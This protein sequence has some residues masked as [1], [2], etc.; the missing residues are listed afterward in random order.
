M[1]VMKKCNNEKGD[2][3]GDFL[4]HFNNVDKV[5]TLVQ[6][7]DSIS[8]ILEVNFRDLF[9]GLIHALPLPIIVKQ[10]HFTRQVE[11][12]MRRHD[13]SGEMKHP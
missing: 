10:G 6:N 13:R 5:K 3:N 7:R 9:Q 11:R 8:L 2:K 12:I 4:I 1:E